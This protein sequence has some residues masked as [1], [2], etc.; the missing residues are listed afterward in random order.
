MEANARKS[1]QRIAL[2]S[3][4]LALGGSTTFLINF[5]GELVRRGIPVE[6]FSFEKNHPLAADFQAQNI[7]VLCLDER[8]MIFE[9]R[10]TAILRGLR[11]FK[12]TVV[13]ANLGA[14]SFEV[15]RHL[16]P[17]IFRVGIVHSDDAR[18]NDMVEHYLSHLDLLAMVSARIREMLEDRPHF[19]RV[20]MKYLPLGV[21]MPPE[22][23]FPA[24][25]LSAPLRLLYLGRLSREQK[26][27][28]LFPE[29]LRQLCAGGMPFHW[30]IA[31]EGEER[32]FLEQN[33][34][35]VSPGQTVSF[36]GPVPYAGV[37]VLLKQHDI[38]LLASDF[39]GLPLSLLEAMGSGLVPV[40]SDLKSGIPEVVDSSNGCLVP[41]DD[42]AGYARAISYLHEHRDELA[43]KSAAARARVQEQFSVAAMTDRWLGAFPAPP[44]EPP[45]WPKRW[46][47]SAPLAA[48]NPVLFSQPLRLLRRVGRKLQTFW[49]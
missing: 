37:P 4:G 23:Q 11:K 44:G 49:K 33:L 7:P 27:V 1:P 47:I 16:P 36:A 20:S 14:S 21:P 3:G 41:V 32:D 48:K 38:F 15:L 22:S 25:D 6:V 9:D 30:T 8:R 5:A 24:R 19:K 31:G 10:L 29:I 26:R 13:A 43:A 17:C 12:P 42:V 39:E 46:K 40:V 28:H 18:V 2:I 35:P 34:K 45:A